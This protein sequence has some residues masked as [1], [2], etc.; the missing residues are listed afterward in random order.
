MNLIESE[1]RCTVY[2]LNGIFYCFN[3]TNVKVV[4][5]YAYGNKLRFVNHGKYGI[6][7]CE[8]KIKFVKGTYRI[9][10]YST[11]D[12]EIYEEL[13]FD[14]GSKFKTY[15]INEFNNIAK[16]YKKNKKESELLKKR[17]KG[18]IF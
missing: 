6:D 4:D 9:G 17:K 14:Y 15:W 12:I 16:Q 8:V 7:N 13:F 5:A 11:R 10:F 18:D 1:R 3:L 2:D